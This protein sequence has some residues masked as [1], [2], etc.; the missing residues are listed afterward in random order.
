MLSLF[1]P[2]A[3]AWAGLPLPHHSAWLLPGRGDS[4]QVRSTAGQSGCIPTAEDRDW[5]AVTA[6]PAT[7]TAAV[8]AGSGNCVIFR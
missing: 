2:P 5:K 1:D 3:G 6:V 4:G 8:S 7:S